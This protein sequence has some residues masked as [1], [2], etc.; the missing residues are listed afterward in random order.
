MTEELLGDLTA[1]VTPESVSPVVAYL[2][3]EDCAVTGNIYS[4]AGGRVARIFVAETPG[5][6]LPELTPEAVRDHLALID[7]AETYFLPESLSDA[8]KIIG[9]A[10][11]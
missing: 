10:L 4:V 2:A 8:T 7:D 3:H 1:K 6:I 11:A 5:A 9:N